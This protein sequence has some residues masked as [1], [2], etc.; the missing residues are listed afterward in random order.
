MPDG[1]IT[2]SAPAAAEAEQGFDLH[3]ALSFVWRQWRFIAAITLVVLVIGVVYLVQAIPLYTATSLV[4]LDRQHEKP[5]GGDVIIADPGYFDVAM[6]ES[7]I[8][9]IQ[10]T[11]FLRRVVEKE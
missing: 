4:Q 9:I 8:A 11:V 3:E 7:Q 2:G 5:P 6:I 1:Y 10:S